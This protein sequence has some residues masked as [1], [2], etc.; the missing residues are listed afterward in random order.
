MG[1][2]SSQLRPLPLCPEGPLQTMEQESYYE[3]S[4]FIELT[5]QRIL[6]SEAMLASFPAHSQIWNEAK[7]MVLSE[8]ATRA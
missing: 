6:T 8:P 7:V 1:C 4:K 5:A 2:K 3:S